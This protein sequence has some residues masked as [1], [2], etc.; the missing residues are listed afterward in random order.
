M[1]RESLQKL[2]EEP[3]PYIERRETVMRK[4]IDVKTQ[5]ALTLYYLSDE[6]QMRKTALDNALLKAAVSVIVR[7]VC[8]A[9]TTFLGPKYIHL[10]TTEEAVHELVEN[11]IK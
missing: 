6:G 2:C 5:V 4:P 10:P 1:R 7:W 3:R 8:R 11:Y 9:V